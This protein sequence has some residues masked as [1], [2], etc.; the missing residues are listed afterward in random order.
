[1]RYWLP[2]NPVIEGTK[3]S[4][5]QEQMIY[6]QMLGVILPLLLLSVLTLISLFFMPTPTPDADPVHELKA[7]M[8]LQFAKACSIIMTVSLAVL[9]TVLFLRRKRE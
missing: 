1:M 9:S 8:S 4:R 5:Y 2:V 3:R 7:D 6:R